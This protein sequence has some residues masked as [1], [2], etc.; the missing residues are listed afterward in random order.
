MSLKD[1]WSGYYNICQ[2]INKLPEFYDFNNN[3]NLS[4]IE[5]NPQ[6]EINQNKIIY[7]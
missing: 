6:N 7:T 4:F 1:F 3:V 2:K 5:K